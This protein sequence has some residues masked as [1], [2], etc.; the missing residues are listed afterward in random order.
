MKFY[1]SLPTTNGIPSHVKCLNQLKSISELNILYR[2]EMI[3]SME[4]IKL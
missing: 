4:E 2:E 1:R 3:N